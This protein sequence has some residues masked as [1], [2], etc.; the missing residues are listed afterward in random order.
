MASGID[1][2]KISNSGQMQGK[3]TAAAHSSR[4]SDP[5]RQLQKEGDDEL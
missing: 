4:Q 3:I 1:R 5:L 2:P